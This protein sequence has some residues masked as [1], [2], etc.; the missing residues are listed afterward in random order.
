MNKKLLFL[1]V[2]GMI[3]LNSNAQSNPKNPVVTGIKAGLNLTNLSAGNNTQEMKPGFHGGG[4]VELPLS[5]YKQFAIQFELLYS[6]QGYNGKEYELRDETNG[7]VI[8]TNTLE[9]VS[10]HY[11]NI[12][13]MFKYYVSDNFAIELGPQIG[14]LMDAKG[15]F[16]L[17][18]YNPAK[19]Y[20]N[21]F[22]SPIDQALYDNGY[23]SKD[24]KNYYEK[25]DYGIAGGIS[26]NFENGFFISGRY[27]LGLQDVYK[28]DNKYSLIPVIPGLPESM[29][30]E[31]NKINNDLDLSKA[32]NTAF[33]ISL[34]YRF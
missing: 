26:Y 20:L 17:Y 34:G 21:S 2:V 22:E 11:L 12:P 3:A 10:L 28:A 19:E 1:A 14:F 18:R 13:V 8:E 9:D 31:I 16:D 30:N 33:Q 27:Y 23:R 29:V 6:N 15:D 5:Y 24:Y 25:L 7:K 4:F 32:K